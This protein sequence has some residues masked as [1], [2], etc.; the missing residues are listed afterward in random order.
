MGKNRSPEEIQKKHD[1]H[2]QTFKHLN[3]LRDEIIKKI[4]DDPH[5]TFKKMDH[6]GKSKKLGDHFRSNAWCFNKDAT[7]DDIISHFRK[8]LS[9][10]NFLIK[11]D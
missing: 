4:D 10:I 1:K 2:M 8:N 6:K 3:T 11:I 9:K 7:A 5:L